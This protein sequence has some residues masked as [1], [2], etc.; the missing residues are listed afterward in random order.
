LRFSKLGRAETS[1]KFAN[2]SFC[3]PHLHAVLRR[4]A[5]VF[6]PV[7]QAVKVYSGFGVNA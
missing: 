6:A 2:F 1:F 4:Y 3:R 7:S 5:G